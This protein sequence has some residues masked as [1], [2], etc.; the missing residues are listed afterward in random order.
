MSEF[1]Y[2]PA[3]PHIVGAAPGF[4]ETYV[5][6]VNPVLLLFNV[7]QRAKESVNV[8]CEDNVGQ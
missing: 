4:T 1:L 2:S 8:M 3:G 6:D 7:K 5:H